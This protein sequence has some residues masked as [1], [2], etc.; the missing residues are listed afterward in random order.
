MSFI[1]LA[2]RI[3]SPTSK[4]LAILFLLP[5]TLTWIGAALTGKAYNVRY[6]LPGLIGFLGLTALA[7]SQLS[8]IGT[9]A[10]LAMTAGLFLWADAQRFFVTRFWKEDSRSA[11]A[12]LRE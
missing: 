1:A 4:S 11:V 3:R 9:R 7:L 10:A 5:V 2:L 12:W 6:T 8:R